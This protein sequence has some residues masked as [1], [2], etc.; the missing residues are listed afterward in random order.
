MP[1]LEPEPD[2]LRP[3]ARPEA[4]SPDRVPDD[5]AGVRP[6]PCAAT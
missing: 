4:P 3:A 2:A 6:R 5:R 1:L